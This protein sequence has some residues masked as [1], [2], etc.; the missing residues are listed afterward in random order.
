[1]GHAPRDPTNTTGG[2]TVAT[3]SQ[4]PVVASLLVLVGTWWYSRERGDLKT[5]TLPKSFAASCNSNP[6]VMTDNSAAAELWVIC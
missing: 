5:L 4:L 3:S 2:A 1:M 6:C